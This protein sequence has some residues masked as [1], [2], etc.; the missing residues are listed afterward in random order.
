MY[1]YVVIVELYRTEPVLGAVDF[2]AVLCLYRDSIRSTEYILRSNTKKYSMSA[3][4][5]SSD[6]RH[7]AV[8]GRDLL[9]CVSLA[10][11][12]PLEAGHNLLAQTRKHLNLSSNDVQWQPNHA[13]H[14]VTG[15]STG[16]V[17]LW[18]VER[19]GDALLRTLRGN[20]RAINRLNFSPSQPSH[21]LVAAHERTVR[22]WDI[23]QR[24]STQQ[25][26]FSTTGEA[27]DVQFSPHVPTCFAV[28]LENGILQ[29]FDI[30]SNKQS[31]LQLP[32][33]QGPAYC[34]EWHSEERRVLATGGRDRTV[35]V[36]DLGTALPSSTTSS[37]SRT[38]ISSG[39][40]GFLSSFGPPAS[41]SDGSGP[42]SMALSASGATQKHVVHTLAAV[43]R[44]KWRPGGGTRRW[45]LASCAMQSDCQYAY[46][47]PSTFVPCTLSYIAREN[48]VQ[49][50]RS[51]AL[52]SWPC[53]ITACNQ[54]RICS[55]SAMSTCL[56]KATILAL[57]WVCF[58]SSDRTSGTCTSLQ[59]R[60]TRCVVIKT[61]ALALHSYILRLVPQETIYL[62]Y[63]KTTY[64]CAMFC[65]L[66]HRHSNKSHLWLS[67]GQL[68]MI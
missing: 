34:L 57:I 52:A 27:R 17:L 18:D 19:S 15:A 67:L 20:S 21:L 29:L 10:E 7:A 31:L 5:L 46:C 11:E 64:C 60:S 26:A 2:H 56:L 39:G 59:S 28:A 32:A 1:R 37:S 35:R 48:A 58:P 25:M 36:W 54:L 55:F 42:A 50:W 63:R 12:T 30:R 47:T 51:A 3:L 14:I 13:S 62:L 24:L 65:D 61:C 16:D 41:V 4:S 9:R 45:Q 43:G 8:A 68:V 23:G 49:T 22:L 44:L 33:H 38:K 66:S 53:P 40:F 6:G